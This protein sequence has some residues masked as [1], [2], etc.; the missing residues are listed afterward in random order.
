MAYLLYQIELGFRPFRRNIM[1][2]IES[3]HL[4]AHRQDLIKDHGTLW[5]LCQ[6]LKLKL[7]QRRTKRAMR[8][9]TNQHMRRYIGLPP[10]H[11][12]PD[13]LKFLL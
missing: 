1:T 5:V 11:K 7:I 10:Q 12:P 8:L 13:P 4:L 3:N 6:I 2:L 9:P